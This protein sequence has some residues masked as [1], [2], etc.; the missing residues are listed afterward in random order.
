MGE[1]LVFAFVLVVVPFTQASFSCPPA[2]GA[3]RAV[4]NAC[5]GT[6]GSVVRKSPS[7]KVLLTFE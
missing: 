4:R 6:G 3:L 7:S 2:R 1:G 5:G